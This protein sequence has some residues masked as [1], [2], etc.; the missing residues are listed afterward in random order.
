MG[1]TS[2]PMA[3]RGYLSK[4]RAKH[5]GNASALRARIRFIESQ[6]PATN[7]RYECGLKGVRA[8]RIVG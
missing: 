4:V 2:H 7:Q 6:A 3:K 1:D 5:V 8:R